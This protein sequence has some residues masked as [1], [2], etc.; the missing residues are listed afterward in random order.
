[1]MKVIESNLA[2]YY[3]IDFVVVPEVTAIPEGPKNRFERL[4]NRIS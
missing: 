2:Q 1:M 3:G 4:E